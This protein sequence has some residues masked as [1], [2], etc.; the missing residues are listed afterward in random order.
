MIY[1]DTKMIFSPMTTHQ[2][3]QLKSKS[4]KRTVPFHKIMGTMPLRHITTPHNRQLSQLSLYRSH[5][6][7][8]NQS[9]SQCQNQSMLNQLSNRSFRNQ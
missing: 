6:L 4:M 9:R 3:S 5:N 7:F 1:S 2:Q 8:Q